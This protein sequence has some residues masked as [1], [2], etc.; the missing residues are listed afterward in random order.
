MPTDTG[1][2]LALILT[3]AG[4]TAAAALVTGLVQLLKTVWPGTIS[5]VWQLRSAFVIA[6]LIVGAAYVSAIQAGSLTVSL[7]SVFA[8]VLAWF[9][10]ARLAKSIFDDAT[11]A[12]GSLRA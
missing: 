6:A 10:V 2:T 4:A 7:E 1:L 12:P 3:A 5:G 9:A 11:A 8:I